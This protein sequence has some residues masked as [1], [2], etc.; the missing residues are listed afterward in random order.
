MNIEQLKSKISTCE[1]R[2]NA[3]VSKYAS[4]KDEKTRRHLEA[5]LFKEFAAQISLISQL[6]YAVC[7]EL[8]S[9][10]TLKR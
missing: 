3:C 9:L 7:R 2:I 8:K 10:N 6:N 5:T 1:N 4:Q